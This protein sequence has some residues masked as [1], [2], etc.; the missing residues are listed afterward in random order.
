MSAGSKVEPLDIE[1]NGTV[2]GAYNGTHTNGQIDTYSPTS[3]E[4]QFR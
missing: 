1:A 3:G 4:E 2:N